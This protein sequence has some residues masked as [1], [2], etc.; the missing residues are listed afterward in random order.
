MFGGSG[1]W[2][3]SWRLTN[4]AFITSSF[5]SRGAPR[6]GRFHLILLAA[7][8]EARRSV[9]L[10]RETDVRLQFWARTDSFEEGEEAEILACSHSCDADASWNV[11]KTWVDGEDDNIYRLYDFSLPRDMLVKEFWVKFQTDMSAND[12]WLV[13][14]DLKLVSAIPGPTPTPT[15]TPIP[16]EPPPPAPEPTPTP[17][18]PQT[19]TV[20][21]TE[22]SLVEY[23]FNLSSEEVVGGGEVTFIFKNDKNNLLVHTFTLLRSLSDADKAAP[24]WDTGQ[25]GVSETASRTLTI[26]PLARSLL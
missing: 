20:T 9:D 1:Y 8:S 16:V 21:V 25:K 19:I 18:P 7:R 12:D 10:S 26:P 24:L 14:D 11:L 4:N 3:I 5:T 2:Q 23:H 17:I 15:P 22:I 6:S 13:V